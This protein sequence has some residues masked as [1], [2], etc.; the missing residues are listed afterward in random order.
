MRG[1]ADCAKTEVRHKKAEQTA[2]PV[3]GSDRVW[4]IADAPGTF[5]GG[6]QRQA[7]AKGKH[8]HKQALLG[9]QGPTFC[10]KERKFVCWLGYKF[11]L[12]LCY[13]MKKIMSSYHMKLTKTHNFSGS[14]ANFR[15]S[16]PGQKFHCWS[17]L[18]LYLP[19]LPFW[20]LLLGHRGLC[21]MLNA[22]LP[23]KVNTFTQLLLVA[24]DRNIN[25]TILNFCFW[26]CEHLSWSLGLRSFC[27]CSVLCQ[28]R[29]YLWA[30]WAILYGFLSKPGWCDVI[31]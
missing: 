2:G 19:S 23:F 17:S 20:K 22:S 5:G 15:A 8:K 13:I 3:S 10:L 6:S 30:R 7:L 18:P 1:G 12:H 26:S 16:V 4:L 11:N 9:C 29:L 31:Q 28:H 27:K 24:A 25:P 21:V 14:F